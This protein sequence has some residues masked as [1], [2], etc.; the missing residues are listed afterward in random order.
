MFTAVSET[1]RKL[2]YGTIVFEAVFSVVCIVVVLVQCIPLDKTWDITQTVQGTCINTTALFYSKHCALWFRLTGAHIKAAQ[3]ADGA[4]GFCVAT[5]GLNIIT[6]IWIIGLPVKALR[7]INRPKRELIALFIIFGAGTLAA[8]MSIVRLHSIF[9]Y[10]LSTEPFHDAILVN[11]WSMIELNVAILCAS[12]PPLKLLISP[13]RLRQ[14]MHDKRHKYRPESPNDRYVSD[15]EHS[16]FVKERM[17]NLPANL[18][19]VETVSLTEVSTAIAADSIFPQHRSRNPRNK[20]PGGE[21]SYDDDE[22]EE[23]EEDDLQHFGVDFLRHH[24]S[25]TSV[26]SFCYAGKSPEL[27]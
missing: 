6:D 18:I 8:I 4:E 11:M 24:R 23:E 16:S 5:S 15:Q 9:T 20:L 19:V 21:R 27:D 14:V 17:A 22:E 13:F 12:V 1:L 3:N 7:G 2:C 10:T 25:Q 26:E